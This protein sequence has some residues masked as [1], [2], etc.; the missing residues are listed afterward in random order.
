VTTTMASK[1]FKGMRIDSQHTRGTS[2]GID[3]KKSNKIVQC[4]TAAAAAA[5]FT[6]IPP[7]HV[8]SNLELASFVFV[9]VCES[10]FHIAAHSRLLLNLLTLAVVVVHGVVAIGC[11]PRLRCW[12]GA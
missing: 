1:R 6:C 9:C 5:V 4:F 11:C 3:Q 2:R 7:K 12:S 8:R 10:A